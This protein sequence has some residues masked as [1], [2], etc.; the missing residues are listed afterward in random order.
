MSTSEETNRVRE[1]NT[2]L[3]EQGMGGYR[4][5]YGPGDS[6][7]IEIA[8]RMALSADTFPNRTELLD[9][10]QTLQ[11]KNLPTNNGKLDN[12]YL[13]SS[14]GIELLPSE[15]N[16]YALLDEI[17]A[18]L[19]LSVQKAENTKQYDQVIKSK[20]FAAYLPFWASFKLNP[21]QTD[22]SELA[23]LVLIEVKEILRQSCN[24]ATS[25]REIAGAK[26][27]LVVVGSMLTSIQNEIGVF[28][29]PALAR[30]DRS[31][32][33]DNRLR[34]I[35]GA[36][37]PNYD[38]QIVRLVPEGYTT[39]LEK[40]QVKSG[41]DRNGK[42]NFVYSDD[43]VVIHTKDLATDAH[44]EGLIP[45]NKLDCYFGRLALDPKENELW[46]HACEGVYRNISD[47]N[48]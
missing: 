14:L 23:E 35:Q 29:L 40:I 18:D 33:T 26:S 10:R 48:N 36:K 3:G 19:M 28:G 24:W 47:K 21:N 27:E 17:H 8:Q 37:N 45:I 25:G 31:L 11:S 9:A 16:P 1:E 41:H 42:V 6:I 20:L 43:I 39:L 22:L 46:G 38:C 30:N 2:I 13:A 34:Q 5:M 7:P 15:P 4:S 12:L 44:A 32:H